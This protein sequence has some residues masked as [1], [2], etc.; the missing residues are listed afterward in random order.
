MTIL[1]SDSEYYD[2][3]ALS[4]YKDCPRKYFLRHRLNWKPEGTSLA[5]AFGLA[6]HDAMDVVWTLAKK[7]S[8]RE[9]PDLAMVKFLEAW[10]KQGLP[11]KPDLEQLEFMAPR[12]PAVAHEMLKGYIKSR[13]KLLQRA[14]L[15]AP[16]Q[17]F[18]VPLAG[19]TSVWYIGR[20]DKVIDFDG[21]ILALEHKTTT[22]YK[23]DGGFKTTYIESWY[24]DSQVKG[25]QYG[26]ALFFPGLKQVWV[27]AA[28]VH[29]KV[30]DAFRFIPVE[31][32][33]PL[34]MEWIED[35]VQWVERIK[36]DKHFPK[37]EGSCMGKYG[38][39][40]FLNICR[41]TSNPQDLKGPPEGY[42]VEKWEPFELLGL[43]KLTK[44]QDNGTVRA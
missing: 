2:N 27:D 43:D 16:E 10:E 25:Y 13:E 40:P 21:Q 9:L 18:A 19:T 31:H 5:L 17:P 32:H 36:A 42:I 30:H 4:T 38:P 29:A 7:A 6:W 44:E 39:C 33:K 24:S 35:T 37:N 20:L 1:T 15:L 28:L 12:T 8:E 11:T 3:T 14:E 41:T 22:E 23:K 26:G 34:L